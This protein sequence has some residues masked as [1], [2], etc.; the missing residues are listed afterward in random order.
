MVVN[1]ST[2]GAQVRCLND[3]GPELSDPCFVREN[4]LALRPLRGLH[5]PRQ[6]P[7]FDSPANAG[8]SDR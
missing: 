7:S 5:Q 1:Y 4:L 6:R 8:G 3:R 2:E